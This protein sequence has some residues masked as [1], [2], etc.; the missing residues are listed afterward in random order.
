[1]GLSLVEKPEHSKWTNYEGD[2]HGIYFAL[3]K[4]SP[5]QKGEAFPF[6]AWQ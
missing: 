5:A 6:D 4:K 1:M 2:S 3:T